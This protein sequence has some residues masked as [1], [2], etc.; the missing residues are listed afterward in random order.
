MNE[1]QQNNQP[2]PTAED[3]L[4]KIISNQQATIRTTKRLNMSVDKLIG[5]LEKNPTT[6][7]LDDLFLE[8]VQIREAQQ[9]HLH[10]VK[11][12]PRDH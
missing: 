9:D 7:N 4:L 2:K 12:S 1:A 11:N 10:E 3:L 8:V 5:L 6:K